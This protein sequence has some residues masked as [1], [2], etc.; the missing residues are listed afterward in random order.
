MKNRLVYGVVFLIGLAAGWIIPKDRAVNSPE[1]VSRGEVYDQQVKLLDRFVAAFKA[2]DADRCADLYAEDAVYMVPAIPVQTGNRAI[3][4]GYVEAFES[5]ADKEVKS[6]TEPV[7]QVLSM[8]DWAVIRGSGRSTET[9]AGR[10]TTSTYNWVI[11][12]R[13]EPDGSWKMVWDIFTL[14]HPSLAKAQGAGG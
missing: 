2:K 11:I 6:L 5:M 7:S 14:D 4:E 12:S 13:K 1:F 8:G 3:R 9:A 10:D